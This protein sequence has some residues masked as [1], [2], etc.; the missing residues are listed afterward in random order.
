MK[1]AIL[2]TSKLPKFLGE[3]HPNEESLFG[4]DD[5]LSAAFAA[6]GAHAERVPWRPEGRDWSR[7]DL[8]L[9]RS[10]WDYI[11][12]LP[13][14]LDRLA[15]IERAGCRLLNP[16]QT[17]AWNA[18]KAYL[19]ELEQAGVG[20]VPTAF[21]AP[22]QALDGA[23]ARL[24][25]APGGYVVK[26]LVG[27]GGFGVERAADPAAVATRL[28]SGSAIAQPFLE[29]VAREGEWSFVFGAGRFLYAAL[30]TPKSGDFRVQVMYGAR[31]LAKVP[32]PADLAAA[33]ACYRDLPVAAPFARI[34]MAR[35]ED[36]RL[37]LMEAELIEPQLYFADVPEAA[38]LVAGAA[39]EVV[40]AG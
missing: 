37:A 35:M 12:A 5:I 9:V 31:T 17:I 4:E 13:A 27:V 39:L 40:R 36:G 2:S 10:T 3:A 23:L 11:D 25:P 8:V 1:I 6:R 21:L 26:P 30:K 28:T 18:S 32:A 19:A 22:G 24:G 7:F 20:I 29:A 15:E 34:D 33:Q 38:G 16:R 14:F